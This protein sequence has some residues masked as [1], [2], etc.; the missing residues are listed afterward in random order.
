[1]LR[2]CELGAS[3]EGYGSRGVRIV[4]G[5]LFHER[6]QVDHR[7]GAVLGIVSQ[8]FGCLALLKNALEDH[9]IEWP[10]A[11]VILM[12]DQIGF[13]VGIEINCLAFAKT[14]MV[15]QRLAPLLQPMAEGLFVNMGTPKFDNRTVLKHSP[16][17]VA[18]GAARRRRRLFE[19]LL[20]A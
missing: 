16:A 3:P 12:L 10:M 7:E 2:S 20:F 8:F 1:M 19:K 11:H 13:G 4:Q 9:A 18:D 15:D 14:V 5:M 6:L 17:V